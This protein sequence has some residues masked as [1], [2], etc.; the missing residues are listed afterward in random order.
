MH[1][2]MEP[3]SN[4]SSHLDASS[5]SDATS[6]VGDEEQGL[7]L[8]PHSVPISVRSITSNTPISD[9]PED[10]AVSSTSRYLRKKTSQIFNA[11][12]AYGTARLPDVS[13]TPKLAALVQSYTD[14][15]V[16]AD[17]KAEGE[18]V[19]REAAQTS[20]SVTAS[21]ELPDVAEET[22]L[23]RGRKRASWGTQFRILSGRAF[24]NLYRDPALLAAHYLSAITLAGELV[25]V[26]M[27]ISANFPVN[28][29]LFVDY[30]TTASRKHC[31][32]LIGSHYSSRRVLQK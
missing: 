27:Y 19:V 30:S 12:S 1:A 8:V 14:S 13:I 10:S 6:H 18:Q 17:I 5:P 9:Y 21:N 29:Q 22:S 31:R 4:S 7:P 16:A 11:V 23:L 3:K 25:G 2:S 26:V 15:A 28:P 20:A 32:W 24:K